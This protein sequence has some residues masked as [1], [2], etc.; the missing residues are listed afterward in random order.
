[1]NLISAADKVRQLIKQ[2][3]SNSLSFPYLYAVPKTN[4]TAAYYEMHILNFSLTPDNWITYKDRV[5][6]FGSVKESVLAACEPLK[7]RMT[8]SK[9]LLHLPCEEIFEKGYEALHE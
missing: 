2:N 4:Y 9:I 8:V 6:M 3:N 1:V 7:P 5:F